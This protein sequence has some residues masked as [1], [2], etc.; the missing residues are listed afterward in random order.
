LAI[1]PLAGKDQAEG[2][3]VIDAGL[4]MLSLDRI[5]DYLHE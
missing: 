3:V 2:V 5:R 4:G 1:D